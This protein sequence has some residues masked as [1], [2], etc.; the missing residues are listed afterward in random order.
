MHG[1]L[2]ARVPKIYNES[3]NVVSGPEGRAK[4]TFETQEHLRNRGILLM[5]AAAPAVDGIGFLYL[6][7]ASHSQRGNKK[8]FPAGLSYLI[9]SAFV[10]A[11]G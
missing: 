7:K 5:F 8:Y 3:L 11:E 2:H 1:D 4:T 10:I 6:V 9:E